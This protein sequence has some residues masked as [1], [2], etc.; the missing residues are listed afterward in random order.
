MGL[1]FGHNAE[2]REGA[3]AALVRLGLARA[4]LGRALVVV[5]GC[6]GLAVLTFVAWPLPPDLLDAGGTLS[7][8]LTD[9]EG[10][11]LRE[12][13]S[14]SQDRSQLLPVEH[15]VPAVLRDA[16]IA[17]EDRR[18]E[19]HPGIDPLA[20]A[21]A[22]VTNLRQHRVVSGASTLTQQLARTL[23]PRRRTVLGKVQEALWAVRLT[24]H[25]PRE[26][27]LRAYL[28]RVAL[29]HDL[30]GV[31]AASEAYFARPASALSVS[32][33]AVL[34]AIARS[35]ARLDPWADEA[36]TRARMRQ[37]LGR[38]RRAGRLDAE[39][40]RVAAAV[41]LDIVPPEWAFRAPHLTSSLARR[42]GALG[43]ERAVSVQ[44][45]LDPALQHQV[46]QTV[47][48][49]LAADPRLGQA[50]VLVVDNGTGEVL[51]YLGSADFL[52][53]THEGQNDGVRALRQPG[54]AL[55]P[56]AYGLALGSGWTA[57]SVLS[58]VETEV[59]TPTGAWLPRNYDR[60]VHG[61][62]RLRAALANSYNVPAVQLAEALGA[63]RVLEVLRAAGFASLD[64]SADHYGAGLVLGNGDVSLW[65]LAR[66]Y[67]GLA[68]GG[69]LEPLRL[70]REARDAEGQ[71]LAVPVELAPRRFLPAGAVA[72]LT[73]ILSDE[74]ARAPAFGFDN[75][76]RLP[77]PVAAK[78]G[79]SRA[80]VDNWTVGFTR[81][82]TV[83]VWV[84]NFDGRPMQKVSGITGAGPVFARVMRLAMRDVPRAP[85]VE[86]SRLEHVRVCPLS[87]HRAGEACPG[88]YE[89]VFLA[90]RTPT[91]PCEMHRLAGGKRVL[92]V[93]P[94]FY[95]WAQRERLEVGPAESAPLGPGAAPGFISP[96]DGDEFLVESGIPLASQ[97]IP[98][99][100]Q[101]RAN[102]QLRV[103]GIV[104]PLDRWLRARLQLAAGVHRLELWPAHAT[105]PASAVAIRVR[106]GAGPGG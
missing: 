21:R 80:Y 10:E 1:H 14:R 73:D 63:E 47:R 31:E 68:R 7:V 30:V 66:A 105:A 98:V 82:R 56:F 27:V 89:E 12:L 11:L 67:R 51:A 9:R 72:V 41:P 44:T 94:R 29:G 92:D 75:A 32:Q 49:E 97:T 6:L 35:P 50:A 65:E 13:P 104:T 69:V 90:G 87:G 78:T 33:A 24:A 60:R 54:S 101:G 74:A 102:T 84:G 71:R 52:D 88:A 83:A 15:P 16:F 25:L 5:G 38:M 19:R 55:K 42:L 96:R 20:I 70:V 76:L 61:P 40:E 26:Q 34:A 106:G 4:W 64:A 100:V 86:R 77:F 48:S 8:R 23:V 39:G 37:V 93:G 95:S 36:G 59:D 28:D 46:E 3:G 57:A 79:T 53:P 22:L 2:L 58:D 18:F 45:T 17:S 43:L 81:E 62:V 103:D 85:L 91:E 99:R